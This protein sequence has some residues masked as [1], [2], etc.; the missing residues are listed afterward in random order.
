[1]SSGHVPESPTNG[2]ATAASRAVRRQVSNVS[3]PKVKSGMFG[4]SSNLINSIVGAGM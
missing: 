1:M 3:M 2:D 4:T